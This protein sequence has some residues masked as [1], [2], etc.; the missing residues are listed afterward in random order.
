MDQ[1]SSVTTSKSNNK[2]RGWE[3]IISGGLGAFLAGLG[4]LYKNKGDSVVAEL[5]RI[6]S[7]PGVE[8]LGLIIKRIL[9]CEG[10]I[11]RSWNH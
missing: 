11:R 7:M 2:D 4:D 10:E 6:L 3:I 5:H 1:N 8:E 9:L